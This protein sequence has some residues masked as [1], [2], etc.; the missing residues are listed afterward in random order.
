MN[1]RPGQSLGWIYPLV[2]LMSLVM[3]GGGIYLAVQ[4]GVWSLAAA[5]G[6]SMVAVLCTWPLAILMQRAA[7]SR[8]DALRE[9]I[10]PLQQKVEQSAALL[11]R[12]SEQQLLS[13]RAKAIAYREKDR[14]ALRRAIQEEISRRD[15]DAAAALAD[16]IER[17]FGSRREAERFRQDIRLQREEETRRQVA[18]AIATIDRLTKAEQWTAAAHEADRLLHL[19]PNHERVRLLP[20]E[21]EQR[22]AAFKVQLVETFQDAVHRRDVDGSIELLKKLDHYLTPAEAESLQETARGVFKAKLENLRT[23]FSLAVQDHNWA[24][25]IRIGEIVRRDFPNTTMAHEV[26]DL[27]TTLQERAQTPEP[28]ES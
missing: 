27:W 18:E 2:F 10:N 16:D 24:E 12:I 7:A 28:V 21:I 14:E 6:A 15:F 26:S 1:D 11:H 3:F 25:A 9:T 20:Q 4:K 5:G 17:L 8:A 23:Q 22:K 13:D 19:H